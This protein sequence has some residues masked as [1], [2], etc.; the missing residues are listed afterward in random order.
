VPSRQTDSRS[1]QDENQNTSPRTQYC[2]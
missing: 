2:T 1:E